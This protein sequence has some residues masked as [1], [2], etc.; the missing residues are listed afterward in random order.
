MVKQHC[1]NK[2][3]E[4]RVVSTQ[5]WPKVQVNVIINNNIQGFIVYMCYMCRKLQ[6]F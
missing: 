6:E 1:F 3:L 2:S 5:L 4:C